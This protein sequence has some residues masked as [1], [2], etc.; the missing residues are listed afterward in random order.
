M[1]I[2]L[3]LSDICGYYS[4]LEEGFEGIGQ[5]CL[6]VNAYPSIEYRRESRGPLLARLVE[7][8]ATRRV[9]HERG[10]MARFCY[11]VIQSVLMAPLFIYLLMTCKAFIFGGGVSFWTPYDLW[12]L[13]FFRKRIVLVFHG[14]DTRPP[15]I[16]GAFVGPGVDVERIRIETARTK[17]R[18]RRLERC[19]DVLVNHALTA[20]LHEKPVVGWLHIGIPRR[21]D[22]TAAPPAVSG[23]C[24]V[25]HAPTRPGPKGSALI[26]AA[27]ERLKAR[28][29]RITYVK[30]VGRTN[31]E[32]LDAIRRCDFVVDELFSDTTMAT[33]ALE[34]ASF[35][36]P[37][38]VGTY[39][40]DELSRVTPADR[41]PP[42]VTC[43]AETVEAAIERLIT[44]PAA[45]EAAGRAARDFVRS[46]WE[47]ALV[48]QRFVRLCA[49]EVPGEWL[50]DPAT[51]RYLH[52]WGLSDD[53]ARAS[54][55]ALL[56]HAGPS[57]LQLDDK[58]ALRDAFVAFAGSQT[59]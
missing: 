6:F 51:L 42:A 26:E 39:G 40:L 11:T 45:A 1:K 37:A 8:A 25:V 58:P 14:T 44:D 27:L 52:G 33:F 55:G 3:G 23:E 43:T 31:A 16:S 35:G 24:H 21:L 5:R 19:A 47:P 36:R 9:R 29:L 54:V 38:V 10:S 50:F 12:V 34:A 15:F 13:R 48:A 49:G 17:R 7:N 46:N 56:R 32:V 22:E 28:G 2:F 57:A 20:H 4:G 59:V 30:L 41:L 18:L 53:Q